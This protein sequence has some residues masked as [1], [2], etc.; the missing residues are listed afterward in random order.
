MEVCPKLRNVHECS[1]CSGC[2]GYMS[3]MYQWVF[4]ERF[5]VICSIFSRAKIHDHTCQICPFYL[6]AFLE[7]L[8]VICSICSTA[9]LNDHKDK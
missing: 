6:N 1:G 5:C 3:Y 2:S 9:E 4:L 8:C 7:R